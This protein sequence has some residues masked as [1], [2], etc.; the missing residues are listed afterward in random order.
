LAGRAL[1]A[2]VAAVFA[3]LAAGASSATSGGTPVRT[4][5]AAPS[6]RRSSPAAAKLAGLPVVDLDEIWPALEAEPAP[7]GE[8][9]SDPTLGASISPRPSSTGLSPDTGVDW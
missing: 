6:L 7:T 1:A 4:S 8:P 3:V 5:G 9:A 2:H